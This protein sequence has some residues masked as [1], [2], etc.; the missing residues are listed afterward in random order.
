LTDDGRR[1]RI[2]G[3]VPVDAD[4]GVFNAFWRVEPLSD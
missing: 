1:F 2:T 3:I 4:A